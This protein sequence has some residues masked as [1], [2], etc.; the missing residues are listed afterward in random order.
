ML[1]GLVIDENADSDAWGDEPIWSNGKLV[2]NTTSG[3]FGHTVG[4][5]IAL[6]Y[7][8]RSLAVN[9]TPVTVSLLGQERRARVVVTPLI[10]PSGS[11]MRA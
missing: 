7:V 4:K 9:D 11:R 10:D 2:G 5:S 8:E 6:G 1:V 3:M